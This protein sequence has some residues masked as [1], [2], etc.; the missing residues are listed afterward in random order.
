[1]QSN[2]I[3]NTMRTI[4]KQFKLPLYY[5]YLSHANRSLNSTL[6]AIKFINFVEL[7]YF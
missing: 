5:L 7:I 4:L 2:Y 6:S 1:M 3:Q